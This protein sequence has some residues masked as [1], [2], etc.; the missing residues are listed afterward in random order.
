MQL[1]LSRFDSRDIEQVVHK[2]A[3]LPQLPIQD[4][5]S[6]LHGGILVL[7][8]AEHFRGM[9][10]GRKRVPELMR[11]HGNKRILPQLCLAQQS[12][13]SLALRNVTR[14]FRC[15]DDLTTLIAHWRNRQGN[16]EPPPVLPHSYRLEVS[17]AL[18]TSYSC[19]H[20]QFLSVQL[21]RDDQ[22]D[23]LSDGLRSGVAEY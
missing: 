11:Y 3:H 19:Q 16:I 13:G 23:G 1:E 14:D 22:G 8:A 9:T 10:H 15:A 6:R 5:A 2:P 4:P 7:S 17:D 18:S 12:L 20:L 21:R